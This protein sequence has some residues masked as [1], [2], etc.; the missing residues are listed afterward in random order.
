M[1]NGRDNYSW[2]QE[3]D[4]IEAKK[5]RTAIKLKNL[6]DHIVGIQPDSPDAEKWAFISDHFDEIYRNRKL[7]EL[8]G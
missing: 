6:A 8:L 5:A 2:E 7:I 3:Q 1:S 4:R